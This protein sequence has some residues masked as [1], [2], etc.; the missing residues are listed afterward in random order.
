[1]TASLRCSHPRVLSQKACDGATG[2]CLIENSPLSIALAGAATRWV[3]ENECAELL[4]AKAAIAT[5]AHPMPRRSRAPTDAPTHPARAPAE[6]GS[7][8]S[9]TGALSATAHRATLWLHDKWQAI[10]TLMDTGLRTLRSRHG[11]GAIIITISVLGALF[12]LVIGFFTYRYR[13]RKNLAEEIIQKNEVMEIANG[14][15]APAK[16]GNFVVVSSSQD[17][18]RGAFIYQHKTNKSFKWKSEWGKP[19]LSVLN[20]HPDLAAVYEQSVNTASAQDDF[21]FV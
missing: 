13:A 21:D 8:H 6:V 19:P 3:N 12:I 10:L 7:A 9:G 15:R 18:P 14:L 5:S 17:N 16:H 2:P 4:H 11:S 20:D 1:M